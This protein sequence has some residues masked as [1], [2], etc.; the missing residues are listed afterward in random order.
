VSGWGLDTTA[1]R[2]A[3]AALVA[4]VAY[5]VVFLAVA[6]FTRPRHPDP[7]PSTMDPP[8]D[9]PPAVVG[10]LAN[11][12]AVPRAAVPATL[13]DLA[14]R[15]HLDIQ[16][17][18]GGNCIVRIQPGDK[19]EADGALAPYEQRVL[20]L[21]RSRSADGE[22]PG[23]ALTTGDGAGAN[24]WWK[25]FVREVVADARARR[26]SRSRFRG[27]ELLLLVAAATVPTLCLVLAL[28]THQSATAASQKVSDAVL[29]GG[30]WSYFILLTPVAWLR[31]E[32]DT[33]EGLA[34][35]GRWM[36]LRRF[37]ADDEAFCEQPP[38]GVAIWDRLLAYG[39]ALGVARGVARELPMGVESPYE[40]WS[41]YGG[42]WHLVRIHYPRYVP[43]AWGRNP[44][45][46]GLIGLVG[47]GFGGYVLAEL[48]GPLLSE[49][50]S[51]LRDQ[52]VSALVD[53]GLV[54]PFVL[55]ALIGAVVFARLV[56]ML[57]L[58]AS[59][60]RARR[61]FTG[62]VVRKR[63]GPQRGSNKAPTK[64]YIAI[65]NG[66]SRE[67]PALLVPIVTAEALSVGD[68]VKVV[69]SPRL[70]WVE[71]I[72]VHPDQSSG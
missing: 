54:V 57:V 58:G 67:V 25:G 2:F 10:F 68:T 66:R 23:D 18:P 70:G 8:G 16:H 9:E 40:A 56:A 17:V 36:G 65:D 7:G 24:R 60:L 29:I 27:P 63:K 38:A 48:V 45:V 72:E 26:L 49:A 5:A 53:L 64:G 35:A 51:V 50:A 59:D 37:L 1:G 71:R 55:I 13:V 12:W 15:G 41:A 11:R 19:P 69:V 34:V 42:E 22:V 30:F 44:V 21:V 28:S 52:H 31:A 39:T 46:V 32:R 14:A 20:D 33:R 61:T 6:F 43:P 47:T 3:F 62:R 4:L